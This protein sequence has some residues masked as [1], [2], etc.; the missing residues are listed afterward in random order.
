MKDQ[1]TREE[2]Q[3]VV[4]QEKNQDGVK[5]LGT[6]DLGTCQAPTKVQEKLDM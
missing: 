6:I 3:P 5:I 2:E 4:T 1:N